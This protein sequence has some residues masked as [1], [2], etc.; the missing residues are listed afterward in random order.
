M[1]EKIDGRALAATVRGEVAE[2]VTALAATGIVPGLA[3]ILAG[4]DPAS[5]VYVRSKER[6][7][8]KVGITA[9]T[10]RLPHDVDEDTLR[11][12]INTLNHDD[13]VDGILVQLPLPNHLGGDLE[14]DILD[15]IHP[16]KDVDGLHPLNL[17]RL[18]AGQ[19]G[20][21][22]CTPSGCMRMLA[23]TNID[24]TGKRAVVIG[25]ST[26]VGKPIA[27][28]L[29]QANATVTIC[30][31]RTRDLA[32]R[33]R[34]ADIIIAAVGRPEFVKGDWIKPGAVVIDVG[35]NRLEDGRLVGDVDFN[36]AM[37]VAGFVSPVPGGVGPMTIAYLLYNVTLS[38]ERR[39]VRNGGQ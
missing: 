39:A 38:A 12:H 18:L 17:G 28:L 7:A 34:E 14:A 22:A 21:V 11:A 31:S 24:C 36:Q 15:G 8:G 32:E 3:V 23:S 26:I 20:F 16:D 33:V 5:Q 19:A 37:E 2:R 13:S 6:M 30:H 9:Q 29:L 10:I 35:I 27:Q 25:R 1:A 4:D